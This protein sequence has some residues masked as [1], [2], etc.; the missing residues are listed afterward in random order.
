M[1]QSTN[2][3]VFFVALDAAGVG[4]TGLVAADFLGGNYTAI[5]ADGTKTDVALVLN[6]NLF[7]VDATKAPGLYQ[8][9]IASTENNVVGQ[10]AWS[11]QP[12]AAL[13]TP[14]IGSAE[15]TAVAADVAAIYT[16][17][18][19][20]VG[21]SISADIAAA[22]GK[23]LDVTRASH[24]AAGTLGE[25]IR[26]IYQANLGHVKIATNNLTIYAEDGSTP[27]RVF[28]LRDLTGVPTSTN[29]TERTPI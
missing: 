8:L 5:K 19:A 25:A 10:I 24:V 3:R 13:F 16:R 15:V 26:E 14:V 1:K 7:E 4:K 27:L 9:L 2:T 22:P 28:L 18:G 20:P 11:L 21:A 23:V 12:A 17:I 29:P 6:T